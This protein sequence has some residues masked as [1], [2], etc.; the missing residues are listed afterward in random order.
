MN[1]NEIKT[2]F[3]NNIY[4]IYITKEEQLKNGII[5]YFLCKN[6]AFYN[7]KQIQKLFEQIINNLQR[8]NKIKKG[9]IKLETPKPSYINLYDEKFYVINEYTIS[10]VVIYDWK[11]N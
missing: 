3:L 5:I 7:K 9:L 1:K 2:I 6:K 8:S 10:K 11:K 4:G